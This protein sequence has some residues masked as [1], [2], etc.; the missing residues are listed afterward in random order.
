MFFVSPEIKVKARPTRKHL[1]R[2]GAK[3]SCGDKGSPAKR[4]VPTG[5][6]R[7]HDRGALLILSSDGRCLGAS[8]RAKASEVETNP[9]AVTDR[10]SAFPMETSS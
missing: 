9:A 5:G 7:K 3:I 2:T 1:G 4:F 6:D 10:T 8:D